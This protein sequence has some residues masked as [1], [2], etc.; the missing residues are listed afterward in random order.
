MLFPI[1]AVRVHYKRPRLSWECCQEGVAALSNQGLGC[2]GRSARSKMWV[3]GASCLG[4]VTAVALGLGFRLWGL[5]FG[6]LGLG[7]GVLGLG[8]LVWGFGVWGLKFEVWGLGFG[9]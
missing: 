9:V 6:V 4:T 2:D 8:F 5:G 1:L 3:L 7:F